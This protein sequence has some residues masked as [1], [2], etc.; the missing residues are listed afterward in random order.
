MKAEQT[1]KPFQQREKK[2]DS[3]HVRMDAAETVS[4][5]SKNIPT[6]QCSVKRLF[7]NHLRLV[8]QKTF[9]FLLDIYE[10]SSSDFI[11]KWNFNETRS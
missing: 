10:M 4:H 5:A 11:T 2:Q 6:K 9:F 3:A 7:G 8:Q 1:K